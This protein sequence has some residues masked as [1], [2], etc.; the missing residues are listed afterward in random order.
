[1]W[2]TDLHSPD[3]DQELESRVRRW[4]ADD[5]RHAAAFEQATDNWQQNGNIPW[6]PLQQISES[7]RKRKRMRTT[8]AALAGMAALC[9]AL[10]CTIYFLAGRYPGHRTLGAAN[11]RSH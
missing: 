3:R 10:A 2:V 6:H 5:P 11:S 7:A 8:G 4:I 9:A 1:M